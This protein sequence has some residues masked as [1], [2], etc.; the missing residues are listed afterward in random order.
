MKKN[1][2]KNNLF[3]FYNFL[4]K[5]IIRLLLKL[6]YILLSFR[7]PLK[8]GFLRLYN[9][10]NTIIPC[11]MSVIDMTDII[12]L[13]Y[14][15]IEDSSLELVHQYIKDNQLEKKFI[16]RRYPH[17]VLTQNSPEYKSGELK[18][19][20]T[21]SAYYEFGYKICRRLARFRNGFIFK[22][23]A[24]QIYINNCFNRADEM[25]NKKKY[26]III[27]SSGGYNG[28]V[29]EG[30][31]YSLCY[32]PKHGCLNGESGDSLIISNA[33]AEFV[34]FSMSITSDHAWEVLLFPK[35]FFRFI[36]P[37]HGIMWFHFN[38]KPLK[39]GMLYPL[40]T[41]QY[42]IYEEKILPLLTKADSPYK[43]LSVNSE[44]TFSI[45]S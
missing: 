24:D 41:D 21:L 17:K 16:I 42:A 39:D 6:R 34:H 18:Q 26:A 14:S 45:D 2:K 29:T 38:H 3:N 22:I 40:T 27:N 12:V 35:L 20:N 25:M 8:I 19:E 4:Q 44:K 43:E 5:K 36:K 33:F 31:F 30:K 37:F 28:Y 10:E 1:N 15:D 23:D 11:L 9:E 13:I 7:K 32:R